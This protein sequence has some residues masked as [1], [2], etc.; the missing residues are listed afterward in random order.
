ML[1]KGATGE[2]YEMFTD[3]VLWKVYASNQY[4]DLIFSVTLIVLRIFFLQQVRLLKDKWT[5]KWKEACAILEVLY[6]FSTV[7]TLMVLK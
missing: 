4:F 3:S 6:V 7:L 2:Q 5:V 1:V